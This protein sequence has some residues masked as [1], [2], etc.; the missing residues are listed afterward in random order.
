MLAVNIVIATGYVKHFHQHRSAQDGWNPISVT[1]RAFIEYISSSR[2]PPSPFYLPSST[3]LDCPTYRL[4]H[5]SFV[6][7]RHILSTGSKLILAALRN[8]IPMAPEVS[9]LTSV[10]AVYTADKSRLHRKGAIRRPQ[11]KQRLRNALRCQTHELFSE[12]ITI[13]T[14]LQ[15]ATNCAAGL[16]TLSIWFLIGTR[17]TGGHCWIK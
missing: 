14:T 13:Q 8:A 9:V 7:C 15:S 5:A 2:C 17:Q 3:S 11:S 4:F 16:V 1:A 10:L 12:L 6:P